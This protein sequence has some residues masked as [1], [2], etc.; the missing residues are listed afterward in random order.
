MIFYYFPQFYSLQMAHLLGSKNCIE[1]LSRD[2]LDLHDTVQSVLSKVRGRVGFVSWKFPGK[3]S[4][5]LDILE[6]LDDYAFCK[7]EDSNRLSHIIMFE[8]VID[9][10]MFHIFIYL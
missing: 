5:E 1:S 7:D 3:D 10:Y 2:V 4:A 9:R 6:M 8:L